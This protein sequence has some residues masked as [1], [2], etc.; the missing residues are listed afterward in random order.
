MASRTYWDIFQDVI[1]QASLNNTFSDSTATT[2]LIKKAMAKAEVR[3]RTDSEGYDKETS[4]TVTTVANQN[5]YP[6]PTWADRVKKMY[7]LIGNRRYYL[8]ADRLLG[9]IAFDRLLNFPTVASDIPQYWS[10]QKNEILIFPKPSA[11][12][13]SMVIYYNP[14]STTINSD[15]ANSSDIATPCNIKEWYEDLLFYKGCEAA[16]RQREQFDI[17]AVW[18]KEYDKIF[19]EFWNKV[20]SPTTS[21]VSK[22]GRWRFANPNLYPMNMTKT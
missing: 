19:A 14:I 18:G 10:I 16:F 1:D 7:V 3:A 21:P 6:I 13:N 20:A 4:S 15:P 22:Y 2:R 12:G 9:D 17:A 8:D 5:N 11:G